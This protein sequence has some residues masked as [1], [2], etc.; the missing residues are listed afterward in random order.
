LH[1]TNF[2]PESQLVSVNQTSKNVYRLAR[3]LIRD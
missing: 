1:T 3:N 2:T